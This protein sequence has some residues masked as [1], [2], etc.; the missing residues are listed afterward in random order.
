MRTADVI[1]VIENGRLRE[2]GGHDQL[3]G[4]N[5]LYAAL[6]HRQKLEEEVYGGAESR[7]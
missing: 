1:F 4:Q 3:L 5:G 7:M 2:Q 6:Y